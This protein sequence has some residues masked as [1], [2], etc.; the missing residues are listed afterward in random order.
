[1]A[2]EHDLPAPPAQGVAE[3]RRS[4]ASRLRA[5]LVRRLNVLFALA[6]SDMR[7]RYGR[8]RWKLVKWLA[9]PFAAPFYRRMGMADVGMAPSGS[10]P[11]RM[12]PRLAMPLPAAR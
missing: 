5:G 7:A 11:G 2:V 1:M 10:I 3:R 8:G 9:D 12:L 4:H 6:E